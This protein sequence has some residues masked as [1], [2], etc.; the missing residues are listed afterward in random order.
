MKIAI[1][2]RN[3]RLYS[4]ARLV[5]AAR[6]R[7][8]RVRVLDPLRCYMRI[9]RDG[10]AVHYR[11]RA[12]KGI[13]AVIPRIGASVTFYGTAVLRQ[14]E[15]M[16][17][18][19]PSPSAAVLCARDKLRSLQMLAKDGV[20]L[21]LTV[22]GDNPDDTS[23][24]LAML[25]P[26]PHVIK[27]NEGAQGSGV[28]LAEKPAASQSVIE[29][30]RGLYA[31][32]LVQ[33]FVREA[34]GRDIRCF[35]VGDRVVAAMQRAAVDGDFRANLHRGGT[36]SAVRLSAVER[37]AALRATRVLGLGIAGVDLLRSERGPLVLEVN[38][39]PGLEGIETVTGVDVADAVIRHVE[40]AVGGTSRPRR[41]VSY[42]DNR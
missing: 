1:L 24:L 4:T 9:S 35:V 27:L 18:Y 3:S 40:A 39:S 25:G 23:D 36:G 10:F 41:D 12:L 8:H 30:F 11:G 26:P 7:G 33:Q 6:A 31:N 19:T 15:M 22:F 32:F 28:V 42:D 20:D 13:D 34:N 29:A 17:V 38:A 14:F 16:G 5:A 2:S 21:P 37:R